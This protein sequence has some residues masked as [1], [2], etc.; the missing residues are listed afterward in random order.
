MAKNTGE[1]YRKGAVR[2]RTEFMRERVSSF[3]VHPSALLA[4]EPGGRDL[5]RR[6]H[7]QFAAERAAPLEEFSA[8]PRLMQW[9][10]I[11]REENGL[12][13]WAKVPDTRV[14]VT[15]T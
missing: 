13:D 9:I 1:G 14:K 7:E 10:D 5:E 4:F 2:N 11:L 3:R 12:P 15:R 8:S 6:R